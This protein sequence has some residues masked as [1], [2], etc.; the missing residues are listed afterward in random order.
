MASALAERDEQIRELQRAAQAR[1]AAL[2]EI[3]AGMRAAEAQI[4]MLAE[5]CNERLAV[6]NEQVEAIAALRRE[7]EL[8]KKA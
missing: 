3:S 4:Q 6:I 2:E 8:L 7:N 5:A 1:L